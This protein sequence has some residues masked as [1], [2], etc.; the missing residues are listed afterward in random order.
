MFLSVTLDWVDYLI[1]GL[2]CLVLVSICLV[3]SVLFFSKKTK[4]KKVEAE[5]KDVI[6]NLYTLVIELCGGKENI[7]DVNS[8]GSRV[9]ILVDDSAKINKEGFKE[10][11]VKDVIFMSNKIVILI[12]SDAADFAEGIKDAIKK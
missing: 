11:D 2:V 9:S 1:I 8:V 7:I 12:G 5:S 3:V 10:N 6:N 4:L